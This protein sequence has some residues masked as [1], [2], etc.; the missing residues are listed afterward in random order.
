MHLGGEVGRG[1]GGNEP[2]LMSQNH[3]EKK[4][5][6]QIGVGPNLILNVWREA[7]SSGG[8]LQSKSAQ[9][10]KKDDCMRVGKGQRKVRREKG[11]KD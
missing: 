3:N 9:I 2:K 6:V 1:G 5:R 8:F 11:S 7:R 10:V 4:R